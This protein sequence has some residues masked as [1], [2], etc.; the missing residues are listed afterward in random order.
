MYPR[1]DIYK[2]DKSLFSIVLDSDEK[3][4]ICE[5][6][7]TWN[8]FKVTTNF[9]W[10]NIKNGFKRLIK[11]IDSQDMLPFRIIENREYES[12]IAFQL[13]LKITFNLFILFV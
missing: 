3:L 1:I 6:S 9:D 13:S 2:D 7:F 5:N 4:E 10:N 12:V 8:S 11:E